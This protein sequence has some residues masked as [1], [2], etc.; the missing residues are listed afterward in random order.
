MVVLIIVS[1][2]QEASQVRVSFLVSLLVFCMFACGIVRSSLHPQELRRAALMLPYCKKHVAAW[3]SWIKSPFWYQVLQGTIF[4]FG[5]TQMQPSIA[6]LAFERSVFSFRRLPTFNGLV[7]SLRIL[8]L[9]DPLKMG[10]YAV[11]AMSILWAGRA[12]DRL[13]CIEKS[14]RRPGVRILM[15]TFLYAA[16]LFIDCALTS[17]LDC[18]GAVFSGMSLYD[19]L[20]ELSDKWRV[21]HQ[22][23]FLLVRVSHIFTYLPILLCLTRSTAFDFA[24]WRVFM[25]FVPDAV[26]DW[27]HYV[28]SPAVAAARLT[29]EGADLCEGIDRHFVRTAVSFPM[30]WLFL[31]TSLGLQ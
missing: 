12:C 22:P 29:Y 4:L 5:V 8:S 6:Q 1:K 19:Q 28:D 2:V 23:Q 17:I 21:Y 13:Y 18:G 27:A 26:A 30:N 25:L 11:Y 16:T 15:N 14:A 31:T 24:V 20:T 7:H 3:S 10:V 9:M